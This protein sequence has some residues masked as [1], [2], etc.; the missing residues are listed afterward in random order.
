VLVTAITAL[1]VSS[2]PALLTLFLGGPQAYV[3]MFAPLAVLWFGFNPATMSS[4]RLRVSF[5]LISLLY[6]IS[7]AVIFLAFTQESIARAFFIAT[8]M[9]RFFHRSDKNLRI[10]RSCLGGSVQPYGE[11]VRLLSSSG[12]RFGTLRRG[13]RPAAAR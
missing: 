9:F 1:V 8:G 11:A 6:G 13:V 5:F 10:S 7:F 2:S 3:I 12:R 4:H